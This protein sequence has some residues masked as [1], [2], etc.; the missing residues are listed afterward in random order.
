MELETKKRKPASQRE[1]INV[2]GVP[3]RLGWIAENQPDVLIALIAKG[4]P[5]WS[6]YH[7]ALLK[8]GISSKDFANRAKEL[9]FDPGDYG[10]NTGFWPDEW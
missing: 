9:G 4:H 7:S 1:T 2:D 5:R 10:Q 3:Q 6:A 8:A